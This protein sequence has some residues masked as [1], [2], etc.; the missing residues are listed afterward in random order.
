MAKVRL[1]VIPIIELQSTEWE[2]GFDE[3]SEVT[4]RFSPDGACGL[5]AGDPRGAF[6]WSA[7]AGERIKTSDSHA[8]SASVSADGFSVLSANAQ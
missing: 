4:A 6:I 3:E 5:T 2:C 1:V 8:T 7:E